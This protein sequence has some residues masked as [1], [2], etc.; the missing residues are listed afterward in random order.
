[1]FTLS[2]SK[3]VMVESK[4]WDYECDLEF[5]VCAIEEVASG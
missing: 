2:G 5:H 1:M 3:G 4:S